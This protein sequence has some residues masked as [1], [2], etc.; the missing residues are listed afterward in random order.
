[1]QTFN[2]DRLNLHSPYTVWHSKN[3]SLVFLTDYN[4][5][6]RIVFTR[7]TDIW[8]D[9]EAYEFGLFNDNSKASPN[10]PKVRQTIQC[11]I[12]EFFLTNP[13]I[14]LYQCE[15]G[16]CRQAIRARLFYNWFNKYEN[17]EH[18]FTQ[19]SILQE[20]NIDNYIAIIVQKSNPNLKRIL[21]DFDSFIGFF[22]KKPE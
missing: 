10:D 18:F 8:Q 20:D 5:Q 2:L 11:I 12:E 6:F 1:M 16:D 14:L 13:N 4:V 22:N 3:D 9:E 7:N 19:V 21:N 15:T 17:K